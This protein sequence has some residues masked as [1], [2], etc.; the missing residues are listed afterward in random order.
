MCLDITLEMTAWFDRF[1]PVASR[2]MCLDITLEMTAWF[3]C[4]FPVA[5]GGFRPAR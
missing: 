5:G 2:R 3:D 4:F 1:F